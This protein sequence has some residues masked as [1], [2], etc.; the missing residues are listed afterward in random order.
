[1]VWY[2]EHMYSKAVELR[3]WTAF[4]A[5][6]IAHDW[7]ASKC[8]LYMPCGLSSVLQ[9]ANMHR[10]L[11]CLISSIVTTLQSQIHIHDSLLE[12]HEWK[13]CTHEPT[14]IW[15]NMAQTK[16]QHTWQYS[17]ASILSRDKSLSKPNLELPGIS[18]RKGA[19]F[20]VKTMRLY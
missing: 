5:A 6:H 15:L 2:S 18:Q 3:K 16:K 11:Q 14:V 4:S 8:P 7:C 12:C 17:C 13:F 20:A 10:P 1:M 9:P 19:K